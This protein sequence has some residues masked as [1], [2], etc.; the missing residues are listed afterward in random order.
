LDN[1]GTSDRGNGLSERTIFLI[2]GR[3]PVAPIAFH[4]V[5]RARQFDDHDQA[6]VVVHKNSVRYLALKVDKAGPIQVR[7]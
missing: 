4:Q 3:S 5:V 2:L 6:P 1:T 7:R